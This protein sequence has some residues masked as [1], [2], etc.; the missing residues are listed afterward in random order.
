MEYDPEP[1][2]GNIDWT[3]ADDLVIHPHNFSADQKDAF[4]EALAEMPEIYERLMA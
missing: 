3:G 1:P 4:K 2:F